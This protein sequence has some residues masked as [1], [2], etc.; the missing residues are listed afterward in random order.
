MPKK[1]KFPLLLSFILTAI[2]GFYYGNKSP[3][4]VYGNP[5]ILTKYV[6]RPIY[7]PP[8]RVSEQQGNIGV[9]IDLESEKI[10][11]DSDCPVGNTTVNINKK[12]RVVERVKTDTVFIRDTVKSIDIDLMNSMVRRQLYKS[13]V[14][15]SDNRLC[16]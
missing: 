4:T 13:P 16:Q 3:Q 12:S 14:L 1:N 9:S 2:I 11:L 8:V 5:I 15:L 10:T 7:V 6:D